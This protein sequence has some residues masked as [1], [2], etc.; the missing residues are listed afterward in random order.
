MSETVFILGAGCSHHAGAPLMANFLDVARDL[1]KRLP[2]DKER[3]DFQRV[4]RAI[5]ALQAAHSKSNIPLENLESVFD[6]FEMA[7]LLGSLGS[8][9]ADDLS[10]LPRSIRTL[11]R[12]TLENQVALPV[13]DGRLVPDR[14]FLSLV[15]LVNEMCKSGRGSS[16]DSVAIITFNYDLCLD[17]AAYSYGLPTT[18]CL[19]EDERHSGVRVLKLH[20]SLNWTVCRG[21]KKVV[22]WPFREYFTKY[23]WQFL[24]DVKSVF[25]NVASNLNNFEH[26]KSFPGKEPFLVPPTWN[27][28]QFHNEIGPVWRAAARELSNAENVF[29]CGYSLPRTDM[30]FRYFWALGGIGQAGLRRFWVFNPDETVRTRFEETLG[31]AALNRFRI[32]TLPF[33]E[34]LREIAR[35]LGVKVP[36]R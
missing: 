29:V 25:L 16:W 34:G 11:I 24:H 6:A 18:Y 4:F 1:M 2:Q 23:S 17:F 36:S 30:F 33:G 20:G 21:C 32:F 5:D 26:C 15:E 10:E 19:N 27:K 31:V 28:T 35:E 14:P 8:L 12:V 22:A 3:E 13:R 7:R 9:N